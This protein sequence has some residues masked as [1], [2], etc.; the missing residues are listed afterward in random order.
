LPEAPDK[1]TLSENH[2]TKE[3]L[4]G[5]LVSVT[6]AEHSQAEFINVDLVRS[7]RAVPGGTQIT[8][9]DGKTFLVTENL[10]AVVEK[11]NVAKIS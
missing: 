4:V 11:M 10:N 9:S 2:Q 6:S 3:G 1:S 8:F 7:V 5:K